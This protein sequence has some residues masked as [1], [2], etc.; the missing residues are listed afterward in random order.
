M[1]IYTVTIAPCAPF[2]MWI[3]L[4]TLV[5]YEAPKSYHRLSRGSDFMSPPALLTAHDTSL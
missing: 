2:R 1:V 3:Q 4:N 5:A